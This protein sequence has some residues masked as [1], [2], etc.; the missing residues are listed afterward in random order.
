MLKRLPT[1]VVFLILVLELVLAWQL[2][3]P[4]GWPRAVA[5]LVV[6]LTL[7]VLY[8]VTHKA[9]GEKLL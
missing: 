8:L 5:A 3:L 4:E 7:V 6:V 9:A 2:R 1:I